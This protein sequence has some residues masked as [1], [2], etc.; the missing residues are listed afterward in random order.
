M[1]KILKRTLTMMLVSIMIFGTAPLSGFVGLELP[2]IFT[3]KAE[4]ARYDIYKYVVF[5]DEVT[6]TDCNENASGDI[7]IPST[8]EGYPVVQIDDYAFANC[9]G[10]ENVTIFDNVEIIDVSA[11]RGCINLKNISLPYSLIYIGDSAFYECEKLTS[12]EIPNNVIYIGGWAFHACSNLVSVALPDGISSIE[13][14]T[15]SECTSLS[16]ITIP[17]SVTSIGEMAFGECTN[18]TEII[19]P[20]GVTYL[21]GFAEC[22]NLTD[23]TI[24]DSVTSIGDCAFWG[25]TNLTNIKIPNS[26]TSIGEMAFKRCK[27]IANIVIPDGVKSIGEAA[28]YSCDNLSSVTIPDSVIYLG[29]DLFIFTEF[30]HNKDNWTDDN[31]LYTGKHL[32]A[33]DCELEEYSVKP[34]TKTIADSAF[35]YC[36]SITSIT[37]PDS[38]TSIGNYA[39]SSLESLTSVTIGNGVTSIGEGAFRGC[40]S[41][42]SITIPDSVTSI[43]NYAFSSLESLTSVTI[44][45]GVTSIGADAFNDTAYYNAEFNWENGV[46]YIENHL[47]EAKEDISGDYIIESDTKTIADYAFCNCNSLTSITIPDSVTSIGKWAFKGCESITNITIPDSVTSIGDFALAYCGSLTSITVDEN[48]LYYSSEDGVL[49]NEEKTKLVQYPRGN[50]RTEYIIPDSVTSIGKGAFFYCDSLT[51]TTIPYSVTS[52][53]EDAFINC[54]KRTVHYIGSRSDWVKIV[55]GPNTFNEVFVIGCYDS[56]GAEDP[57]EM[58]EDTS[59]LSLV[60]TSPSNGATSMS[61]DDDFIIEFN[62]PV[63]HRLSF[64]NSGDEIAIIDYDSD[65]TVFSISDLNAVDFAVGNRIEAVGNSLIIHDIF[66]KLIPGHKYYVKISSGVIYAS[67]NIKTFKGISDKETWTFS[68][69]DSNTKSGYSLDVYFTEPFISL[70]QGETA[71]ISAVLSFDGEPCEQ[72]QISFSIANANIAE[73]TSIKREEE[74]TLV[75]IKAKQN[76]ATVINVTFNKNVQTFPVMV[77]SEESVYYFND[78]EKYNEYTP[79]AFSGMY[80]DNFE[81]KINDDGTATANFD[82]YNMEHCYGVVDVYN[83]NGEIVES[84]FIDL[85]DG[86][87]P[88]DIFGHSEYLYKLSVSVASGQL[89]DIKE[90]KTEVK[91]KKTSISIDVPKNGYYVIT[92]NI[93]RSPSL[94]LYDIGMLM[95]DA[96]FLVSDGIDDLLNKSTKE[97]IARDV[98]KETVKEFL[99]K[100]GKDLINSTLSRTYKQLIKTITRFSVETSSK[101]ATSASD[102]YDCALAL[103]DG[104]G[105]DI[106]NAI[107][108]SVEKTVKQELIQNVLRII[109]NLTLKNCGK[110]LV[111]KIFYGSVELARWGAIVSSIS[112]NTD[113][114]SAY[115]YN[116][117]SV[118]E[119][120]SNGVISYSSMGENAVF[121]SILITTGEEAELLQSI[122]RP[123]AETE[124]FDIAMY[125]NGKKVQPKEPVTVYIPI[126]T[127]WNTSK[128]KVYHLDDNYKTEELNVTIENGY[129]KFVTEGFSYFFISNGSVEF[130]L[131][132]LEIRNPSTTTIN[133]GDSIILHADVTGTLPEGAKIVWDT[134]SNGNFSTEVSA[135]GKTCKIS[136]VSSGSTTFTVKVIAADGETML[137]EDSQDMTTKA[138]F[139]Q[140]IIAFFKKLFKLTKTYPEVYKLIK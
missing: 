97:E 140:K 55:A 129:A 84:E 2:D 121:H 51:S 25:C 93:N 40:E 17:N 41:I 67:D 24:P 72:D 73:I 102:F 86:D 119:K 28:F 36:N 59:K 45:N 78:V 96:V 65:E 71:D 128:I 89:F 64:I 137:A 47:I 90:F 111:D 68:Y 42:T 134:P 131:P 14:W 85:F 135:D 63:D 99:K 16:N 106:L 66:R 81:H 57:E 35:R 103:F 74:R 19:I 82:V 27:S 118:N 91:S 60:S 26:V 54:E 32:I 123:E 61:S 4:A 130:I 94:A 8:I 30:F 62:M 53:D 20:D 44:G 76:G 6:I 23:I 1:K 11:F 7:V 12:I 80:I 49:F 139:F 105:V 15:F 70:S 33:A 100:S 126:P 18:L 50:T 10:I 77:T 127:G 136:P 29:D 101:A 95:V 87:Y 132:K 21:S 31:V 107:K 122:Y 37:I 13:E 108:K 79:F 113:T 58:P 117:Q 88:T 52:I 3:T 48:N 83:G 34:G 120:R 46:L 43:G 115:I 39:F 22:I 109:G 116:P 124:I 138:G 112:E 9:Q 38:V 110:D 133:Y 5:D 104:I 125:Q 114:D 69:L 75:S 98:S 92:K 56:T